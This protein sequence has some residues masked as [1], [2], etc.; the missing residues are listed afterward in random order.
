MAGYYPDACD[1][2]IGVHSC[3]ECV[4]IE[5]GKI[6]GAGFIHKD[7]YDILMADPESEA[8]WADGIAL[9]SEGIINIPAVEGSLGEPSEATRPGFGDVSEF[10]LGFDWSLSFNDPN[11]L[12]GQNCNF[13]N[14]MNNARGLYYFY[15][16]SETQTYI[17]DKPVTVIAKPVIEN[18]IDSVALW[19]VDVKWKGLN[20]PC[21]YETVETVRTCY[22]PET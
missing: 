1:I 12:T 20:I 2:S 17:T 7:Y 10:L 4:S 14:S 6:R 3:V 16:R 18:D 8:A 11:F 22:I 15:Y 21:N 5:H 9:G 13:W 19:K